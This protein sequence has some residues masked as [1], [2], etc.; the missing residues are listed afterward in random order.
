MAAPVVASVSTEASFGI[1]I[2]VDA[3]TGIVAGDV[4]AAVCSLRDGGGFLS[5]PAGWTVV[6]NAVAGT[7]LSVAYV[8]K[9]ADGTEGSITFV[10]ASGGNENLAAAYMRITGADTSLIHSADEAGRTTF[11]PVATV[12]AT[13]ADTLSLVMGLQSDD[14]VLIYPAGYT[15]E[16]IASRPTA[17]VE[18]GSKTVPAGATGALTLECTKDVRYWTMQTLVTP[19]GGAPASNVEAIATAGTI[20]TTGQQGTAG[21][22][23]NVSATATAG[24]IATTGQQG[25]ASASAGAE[26]IA[27][28][29]FISAIGQQG[30]AVA[31]DHQTAA[32]QSGSITTIGQQGVATTAANISAQAIAGTISTAGQQGQAAVTENALAV[33]VSGSISTIGQVGVTSATGEPIPDVAFTGG[34]ARDRLAVVSVHSRSTSVGT[35]SR[36]ATIGPASRIAKVV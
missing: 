9:T 11:W 36:T 17:G 8:T 25:V 24:S 6:Y 32:S 10:A 3:P 34:V 22:T 30:Q 7:D 21:T 15:Q 29:G 16:A 26:A 19:S 18:V 12:T 13:D 35:A 20:S 2:T 14:E 23:A 31:S 5:V 1:G 28:S 4:L 27:Q 33:A